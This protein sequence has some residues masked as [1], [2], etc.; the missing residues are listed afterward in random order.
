MKYDRIAR[1]VDAAELRARYEALGSE[2]VF[3]GIAAVGTVLGA[4]LPIVSTPMLFFLSGGADVHFYQ[5]G[6]SGWLVFIA[7][8]ALAGVPFIRPMLTAGRQAIPLLATSGI[9]IGVFLALFAVSSYGLFTARLGAYAW[10]VAAV[11]LAVGYARRIVP[12]R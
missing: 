4:V 12:W 10:I 5:L 11:T 9:L 7:L 3:F 2:R 8:V 6:F 1:K